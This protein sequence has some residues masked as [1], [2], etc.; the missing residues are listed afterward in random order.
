M[1]AKEY[2]LRYKWAKREAQDIELRITQLRLRYGAP[3]A[4]NYSDMPKAHGS[5]D[6]SDYMVQLERLTDY[7]FEKYQKCIGIETDIYMRL[8]EM[9]DQTEREVLRYRYIDGL[10]WEQIGERMSY[11]RRNITRIHGRALQH[12]PLS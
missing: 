3:S 6:L 8:D 5:S 1:T 2:L 10:T 12:F 9:T 11:S 7:L 4:I